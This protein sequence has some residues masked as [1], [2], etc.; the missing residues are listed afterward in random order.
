[1]HSDEL[2]RCE[3]EI[4]LATYALM[5]GRDAVDCKPV[6]VSDALLY[7]T[8]WEMERAYILSNQETTMLTTS[9]TPT[10]TPPRVLSFIETFWRDRPCSVCNTPGATCPHRAPALADFISL[11]RAVGTDDSQSDE[12]EMHAT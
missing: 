4:V 8:D 6:S 2:A 11:V 5:T 10:Q 9:N 7:L 3:H 1:M 12:R